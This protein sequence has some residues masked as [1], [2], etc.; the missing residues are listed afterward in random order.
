MKAA[1]KLSGHTHAQINI[2]SIITLTTLTPPSVSVFG[3]KLMLILI[4][5]IIN[6]DRIVS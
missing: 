6:V 3:L 5:L 4:L 1:A 2:K